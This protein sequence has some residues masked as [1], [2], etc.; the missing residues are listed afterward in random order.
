MVHSLAS[1]ALSPVQVIARAAAILRVCRAESGG[2]SLGQIAE[3]VGLPRSTVQRIVQA[4]ATEGL[5]LAGSETRS[6]RIGPLIQSLAED[7]RADVVEIA[8]PH[9]K[10]LSETSGETVDLAVLHRDHLV[11]IDQ[12]AGPQRLRAVSSVGESFPLHCT[13]NGKAAL[14]LL[15]DTEIARLLTPGLA[16]H[17]PATITSSE[18]LMAEIARIRSSGIAIDREEH[19]TGIC[20][21]GKAFRDAAATVYA[22]SIPMPS[23]R[24]DPLDTRIKMA[25]TETVKAIEEGALALQSST[26]R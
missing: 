22:V 23:V 11:F 10:R 17:T 9:L 14:A 16:R 15:D 4:L 24:F 25:L 7:Y 8:H 6:I 13:A 20:A 26:R 3:R 5:L 12:I 21:M 2:L 19:A 18:G 1:S